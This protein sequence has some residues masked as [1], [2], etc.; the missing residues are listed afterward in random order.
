MRVPRERSGRV[1]RIGLA[2]LIAAGMWFDSRPVL[3]QEEGSIVVTSRDEL[4][5]FHLGDIRAS[6]EAFY[7]RRVDQVESVDGAKVRDTEDML[8]EDLTLETDGFIG[9]P[10][11]IE[12]D[13][14]VGVRLEQQW[15][16]SDTL[17]REETTYEH[18]YKYDVSALILREGRAPLTLYSRRNQTTIDR[19]FGGSLDST[20][21]EHGARLRVRSETVPSHF[22]YFHR[23]QEQ[24]SAQGITDFDLTQDTFQW[25]S[26]YSPGEG[27]LLTWDY[28]YDNVDESGALRPSNRFERHDGIAIH[29]WNFGPESH[30][31]DLRSTLQLYK[32]TGNFPLERVRLSESLDLRHTRT[33]E[34]R[35]DYTFDQQSRNESRQTFQRGSAGFQHKL[36]ASLVTTGEVG[37]SRLELTE[38]EFRSD[39]QFAGI[40]FDYTKR[41]PYGQLSASTSLRRTWQ[42]DSERGAEIQI[43]D[44]TH[45]FGSSGRIILSR[46]NIMVSSIVITDT[47]GLFFYIE[48]ADYTARA[49]GEQ[50][51]IRRILGGN[52]ADGQL[53]LIDY[54]IGPEPGSTTDTTSLGAAARYDFDEGLLA[55]LGLYVRYR[56]QDQE[57]DSKGR[58]ELVAEDIRDLTYGADY[59]FWRM[60]LRA[61]QQIRDS[62]LSPYEATRLE[63]RYVDRFARG[64]ALVLSANYDLL[65][66][67]DDDV[68][69]EVLTLDG[70]WDQRLTD[71]LRS[72]VRLTWR[73]EDDSAGTDV[74]AFEQQLDLTW[75]YRQTTI[76]AKLRNSILDSDADDSLYQTFVLGI[77]REF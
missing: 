69:T 75:E 14:S 73:N 12:L 7:Q 26:Q 72:S 74:Q 30:R 3:G 32:E 47:T 68:T 21:T 36:F 40:A 38:G 1:R 61:E 19:Q 46:R 29:T 15:L 2:G 48:G 6:I 34:T 67:T 76:Y 70:R 25:Q 53:V 28:T 63:A 58:V 27:Q 24:S 35:Y 39:Q 65:D 55:G 4:E 52:I 13:L 33:F 10:N 43:T 16:D 50:V 5:W 71:R 9:H 22:Q 54:R 18:F 56:R 44:E 20:L 59:D 49:I 42:D 62:T 37:L 64:S 41:V 8:R 23:E 31:S 45:Q 77:R 11:L 66:F 60:Y 57:R 51:E 17:D